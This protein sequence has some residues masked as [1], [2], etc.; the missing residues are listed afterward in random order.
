MSIH[1]SRICLHASKLSTF[2]F[3]LL[4][5]V[6]PAHAEDAVYW[7]NKGSGS[8]SPLP[9]PASQLKPP[10]P[11]RSGH[12][13]S[14]G[15]ESAES[16][17]TLA[18]YLFQ[19]AV[20]DWEKYLQT[21]RSPFFQRALFHI[22]SAVAISPQEAEYW[23][24][25]GML[26]SS[27]KSDPEAMI[28]GTDSLIRAVEFNPGHG[29]AQ[30]LLAQTLQEQGSFFA[31]AQ[32]YRFLLERDPNM[33]TGLVT[34]PLALCQI[35]SGRTK[36]GVEFFHRLVERY[37]ASASARTSLAVLLKNSQRAEEAIRTLSLL[38]EKRLGTKREQ[39][40]AGELLRSW[41]KEGRS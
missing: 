1:L 10:S 26:L 4:M 35:A 17:P 23:F 2:F 18:R 41:R 6:P 22:Q 27:M 24:L 11:E 40:H 39:E 16:H 36:E 29:R 7:N 20:K 13:S 38:V 31:A 34:A 12:P 8:S 21:K 3:L 15:S 37:P 28:R 32:Q 30:L 9:Q 5:L 14:G 19:Q 25:Q 33:V